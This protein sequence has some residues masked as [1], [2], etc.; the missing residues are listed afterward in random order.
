M[1]KK[2]ILDQLDY[3][4]VAGIGLLAMT[5]EKAKAGVNELVKEGKIAPE[6]AEKIIEELVLHGEEERAVIRK[7]AR[8]EIERVLKAGGYVT[9]NDIDVL[10][11]KMGAL[12]L[13][14]DELGKAS[15]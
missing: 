3:Q 12:T 5:L 15:S 10:Y 14:L 2:K 1:R 6:N 11:K 7:M 9:K 13:R 8:Q 4:V